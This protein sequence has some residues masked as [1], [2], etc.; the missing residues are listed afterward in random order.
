M[1]VVDFISTKWGFFRESPGG[2]HA[3]SN[4]QYPADVAAR[5][6]HNIPGAYPIA[7]RNVSA[8]I[9]KHPDN[10]TSEGLDSQDSANST[11]KPEGQSSPCPPMP[12]LSREDP[13]GVA[14][15][16]QPNDTVH[17]MESSNNSTK[18]VEATCT[19]ATDESAMKIPQYIDFLKKDDRTP[20]GGY[21]T[22]EG[23]HRF[24]GRDDVRNPTVGE[25]AEMGIEVS[26]TEEVEVA[27]ER[28]RDVLFPPNV[29]QAGPTLPPYVGKG[30][31]KLEEERT[32]Y[33]AG[34]AHEKVVEPE[35]G[36][37]APLGPSYD[38]ID[39]ANNKCGD[40]EASSGVETH[41]PAGSAPAREPLHTEGSDQTAEAPNALIIK[42]RLFPATGNSMDSLKEV[43]SY[44]ELDGVEDICCS[45]KPVG[46]PAEQVE[47]KAY[48]R[49]CWV[50]DT[51]PR[52][53]YRNP[54]MA[55]AM[56]A[57]L[58]SNDLKKK[59]CGLSEDNG[60]CKSKSS[61]TP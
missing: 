28:V 1:T 18:T 2:K 13:V 26:T 29:S 22:E 33:G 56:V 61:R 11:R 8:K 24:A 50:K 23:Y 36:P 43:A 15:L 27:S 6:A 3:P 32:G 54:L 30:K 16:Q 40:E 35:C 5:L 53:D 41:F 38:S 48:A 42:P 37:K 59:A 17:H 58:L 46:T 47:E 10:L 21:K 25:F 44:E 14:A 9:D 49:Y 12:E 20:K 55:A 7:G 51:F 4:A 34:V 60:L 52:I 57:V 19:N 31:S 45:D 39:E